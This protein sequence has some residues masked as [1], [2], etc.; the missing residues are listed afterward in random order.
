M[1]FH[2]AVIIDYF[3]NHIVHIVRRIRIGGYYGV[4]FRAGFIPRVVVLCGSIFF[5]ILGHIAHQ[6]PNHL[7]AGRVIGRSKMGHTTFRAVRA[8]AAQLL[9]GYLLVRYG[10]NHVRTCHK[11][12]A[13]IFHHEHE[14]GQRRAVHRTPGTRT[15]DGADLGH[16]PAGLYVAVKDISIAPKR[17]H[18]LL[19]AGS[20]AIIQADDRSTILHGEIHDPANFLGVSLCE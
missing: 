1:D 3:P 20:S 11:H 10:L 18:P 14:I 16:H 15:H 13:R 8:R 4:Q 2:P 12:V 19:D 7:E 17:N 9:A 5:A 6:L